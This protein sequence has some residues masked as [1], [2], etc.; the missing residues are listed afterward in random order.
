MAAALRGAADSFDAVAPGSGEVAASASDDDDAPMS[1]LW[2]LQR[3][4]SSDVTLPVLEGAA[5]APPLPLPPV[6]FRTAHCFEGHSKAVRRCRLSGGGAAAA[7]ASA[8][9]SARVWTVDSSTGATTMDRNATIY[10][11]AEVLSLAWESAGDRLLLLGTASSQVKAWN[12]DARRVVG[13][14]SVDAS[15]P[16]VCDLHLSPS[17]AEPVFVSA[18]CS[19]PAPIAGAAA[20]RRGVVTVWSATTFKPLHTLPMGNSAPGVSSVR[21]SG[22]DG[23][24]AAVGA[25]DGTVRLFDVNT[26]ALV[27]SLDCAAA[28]AAP[29]DAAA[30]VRFD[31][32]NQA[33]Y[34]LTAS[35]MLLEWDL[36]RAGSDAR[37]GVSASASVA[38]HGCALGERVPEFALASG[39]GDAP[40]ALL[41]SLNETATLV[42]VRTGGAR[43]A[44]D[45]HAGGASSVGW[46]RSGL[47]L[48]ATGEGRVL[49]SVPNRV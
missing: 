1:A 15:T 44:I 45:G 8:D 33:A 17:S 20:R 31:G 12:A 7:S 35:G 49:I 25:D 11:G 2:P 9:G 46:H 39:V 27:A 47:T 30:C 32:G 34:V 36:R 21:L 43:G 4:D 42:D 23:R 37:G 16:Y 19:E 48:S 38:Q 14:I 5:A 40:A 13:D 6:E 18:A 22:D 28:G 41:T 10:C 24:L 29:G 26:R 3:H